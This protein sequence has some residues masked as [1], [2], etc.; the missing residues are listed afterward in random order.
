MARKE[1]RME[2][3][4]EVLYQ[5]H[6]GRN[7]SQIKRSLQLDRKTI[8]RYIEL[9]ESYGF[10]RYEEAR[11]DLYYMQLAAKV[12]AGLK[13]PIGYSEAF[14]KTALYQPAIEK[15][16]SKKFMTPKQA[17][18]ILKKE[19]GYAMSY[20]SFKRYMNIKY[21]KEPRSC[22]R[23]EVGP[24]EEAQ[25]DFGSAGM[26]LD[27][28]TDKLRR[29]H[30]FVMTLSYSRLPY[31]EFVFDQGQATWVKCH[32][33][34]FQFFQGVPMRIILDNLRSGILRP[35]TYDPVF[36]RAYG[37]C[38]KHYG[39]IIDP[40]KIARGDH[41]GKVERKIPVIR[42]QFLSSGDFR[43]IRDANEK[44]QHWCLL[45][46]GME[47]HG[48][49][50]RKPFEVFTTEEK[51]ALKRLPEENFDIP[52]WKEARVHPDHH[53]VFDN[54]YYSMPSR[55]V[56]KQ[57]WV[58]GGLY[59]VQIFHNGELAK[60]HKRSYAKGAWIT[61]QTD[62]PPEKSRYLLKTAT[63]Y[64]Q[65]ASRY[66]EYVRHV[67]AKIMDEHAYRNLRKV[68]AIFRLSDKYG[69]EVMNLTCRRC[70]F[71]EDYRMT[72]IKRILDRQLYLLPLGDEIA[73]GPIA[74]SEGLSFLRP[75][76]YFTHV[77]EHVL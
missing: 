58:R 72:T 23:I 3:L 17:Y 2:E 77:K 20:S 53:V 75:P 1:I 29:A 18:R 30:A 11:D 47:V 19:H 21:P 71:Y 12:Q 46:Y 36:N 27:P 33:N 45:E 35:N 43:D 66:G 63:H 60:S 24:A 38:S 15:L 10:S 31:V 26:M 61:D 55:Y 13:T 48:T 74:G 4:M 28:E 41:K 50:K 14:K 8:R 64:Q 73:K 16:L 57:V 67:V 62:Y 7:I 44:V 39:F 51:P 34:A 40:A 52:L 65:E 22:L 25:V 49:I 5:S 32:M 76:E 9:A 6:R 42:Q 54:N 37:E 56:G 59:G 69:A 68:Q 70:L